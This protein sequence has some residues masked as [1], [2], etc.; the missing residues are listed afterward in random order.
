[1]KYRYLGKTGLLVSR[2]CLGTMSFGAKNWGCD[3]ETSKKIINLFLDYGGNFID[4]ADT[5][6][7]SM[8]EEILGETIKG[9]KRDDFVL[10]TKCFYRTGTSPNSKGLSRKHIIEACEASLRRLGS[11]YI[12][13]YFIHGSD[14][15]TPYEETMRTLGDLVRAGKIRY[16]GCSNIPAWEIIK[17][18]GICNQL[19]LERLSCGEYN[20]NLINRE[21]ERE[22]LPACQDQGMGFVCWSPLAGGMLTG[23]YVGY[24]NPQEGTR[25]AYRSNVDIPRFW[26]DRGIKISE[27]ISSISEQSGESASKLSLS[28]LLHNKIVTSIICGVKNEGQLRNNM[29]VADWDLPDDIWRKIND[30]TSY[31]M[32][33]LTNQIAKNSRLVLEDVE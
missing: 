31:D 4:T 8:S 17:A 24:Q 5:Y 11:D 18:N 13:V 15:H 32:G 10:A 7:G 6:S 14:P 3:V 19:H 20:Y 21:V 25:F 1:M 30:C 12:D 9:R 2:V 27:E 29:A 16:T 23:K 33:N 28:W 22:V 26:N